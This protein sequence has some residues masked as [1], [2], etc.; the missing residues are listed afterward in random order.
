M[1]EISASITRQ[2]SELA[3]EVKKANERLQE[4]IMDLKLR[5]KSKKSNA[6]ILSIVQE[7]PCLAR[8]N[9]EIR[10][11]NWPAVDSLYGA[12]HDLVKR[13]LIDAIIDKFGDRLIVKSEQ[14]LPTGKQDIRLLLANKLI[15]LNH[16]RK[17]IGIEIKSGK[18]FDTKNLFQLDR[19]LIDNDIL[20]VIRVP[21]GKVY[22]I[23]T[24]TI[25]N[26]LIKN[27]SLLSRKI[28]RN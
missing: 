24:S 1:S 21:Y 20:I 11:T 25:E 15:V 8:C 7:T 10:N 14:S 27:L 2:H 19:Y 13:K 28:Q 5:F 22:T 4:N 18:T 16:N 12:K 3:D 9:Y 26:S 17:R 23:R 6:S